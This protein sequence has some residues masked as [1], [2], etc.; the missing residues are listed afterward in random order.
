MVE[1]EEEGEEQEEGGRTEGKRGIHES[2]RKGREQG[3]RGGKKKKKKKKKK[4]EE[5]G[6]MCIPWNGCVCKTS[7]DSSISVVEN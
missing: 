7:A 1:Q 4:K 2:C 5:K 6:N 3:G